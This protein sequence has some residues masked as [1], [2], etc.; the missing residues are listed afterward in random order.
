MALLLALAATLAA[1]WWLKWREAEGEEPVAAVVRPASERRVPATQASG[2]SAAGVALGSGQEPRF[3]ALG[4]DLFPAHSW[5]PLPPPPPEPPPPPPTVPPLPFQY[6]GRWQDGAGEVYFLA[7]GQ[8]VHTLKRGDSVGP[9]RLDE[10]SSG[11]LVFTYVPM[12]ERHILR[13]TP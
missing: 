13:W 11:Q 5:Q 6:L 2:R 10:T 8:Q 12:N 1:V 7:Q 9:W 3:Q 4:P